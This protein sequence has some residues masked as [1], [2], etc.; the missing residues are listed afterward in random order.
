[1]RIGIIGDVML[2][3]FV[4]EMHDKP[5]FQLFSEVVQNAV[6]KFD[7][8][9]GNLESPITNIEDSDSVKFAD[10]ASFLDCFKWINCFSLSN[11]HINDFGTS[12]MAD[13]M[14]ALEMKGISYNGLYTDTYTPYIIPSE[15]ERIA[16]ITCA[17][18]MN[19]EFDEACPYKTLRVNRADEISHH[20]RQCKQQGYFVVL[21]AH[22]GLLFTRYPNPIARDFVYRMVDEGADCV[23]TAHP[24]CLGGY[25][26]YHD[27][28]I[29]YS[30]GDFLMDG[31]SYR[32]RE[33]AILSLS[34]EGG[35]LKDWDII[36]VY[37]D[38]RLKV[39]L[40]TSSK[41]SKMLNSFR[42]VHNK[43]EKHTTNYKSF[44]KLQ[45]KKELLAHSISTLSF[46][47]DRRGFKGMMR[48]LIKRIGAVRAIARRVV[49]DRSGLSYDA[50]AISKNNISI[51]DIR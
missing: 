34:I 44:F 29:V 30:L 32:R 18:M 33:A 22:V 50:D 5:P 35:V 17:D 1:M 16:V 13:T 51:D 10:S 12:G 41:K 11:N 4:K 15:K 43:L 45:Y 7:C 47:Y 27:K 40:A 20:I 2:G 9:I 49:T 36:P 14:Q 48:T 37:T 31:A 3:R 39:Q 26:F 38:G 6:S 24:H 21:F 23:V 28:L 19:Y 8:S 25:E 42:K 46:E